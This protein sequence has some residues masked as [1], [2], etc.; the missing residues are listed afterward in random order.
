[1]VWNQT[2]PGMFEE[3]SEAWS[4]ERKGESRIKGEKDQ[5]RLGMVDTYP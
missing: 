5:K 4:M 3:H 1:M 2:N